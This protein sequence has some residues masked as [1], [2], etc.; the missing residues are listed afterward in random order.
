MSFVK[1]RS[2]LAQYA[3]D[4]ASQ[5][6]EDGLIE[7]I[8]GVISPEHHY[9]VEFGA[10]NGKV[11]SNSYNLIANHDWTGILIEGNANRFREL[12]HT[13]RNRPDVA[14]LNRFVHFE[15]EDRL[16]A[17]LAEQQAPRSFGLLSIDIDGNDYYVWEALKDHEPEIVVIEFN[18]TVPND[19][20][21]VQDK[22]FAVNQ[23]CSLLALV[24]LGREKGYELAVC[25]AGNAIFVRKDKFPLLDVTDNFH[26]RLFTPTENGR[27]FQGYDGYIHV[28]GMNR[29]HL[30]GQPLS[31]ADFQILPP[32]ERRW[33]DAQR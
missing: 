28:F 30:T 13:Y 7:H 26:G 33:V 12:V 21:F 18:G 29:L 20:V 11:Y 23:G 5:G 8:V 14:C 27:I 32:E 31:S 15:G 9:C 3:R 16:D 25:T 24:L 22:S 1:P 6:G 10:W 2:P 4:V 19:V 17:I